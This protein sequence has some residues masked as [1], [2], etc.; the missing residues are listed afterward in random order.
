MEVAII[1][2]IF[3]T[4]D[5]L[6]NN[7]FINW[8]AIFRLSDSY[9]LYQNELIIY[10]IFQSQIKN[11]IKFMIIISLKNKTFSLME[12]KIVI[13]LCKLLIN[14]LSSYKI[15]KIILENN[16]WQ[17]ISEDLIYNDE[18]INLLSRIFQL[19]IIIFDLFAKKLQ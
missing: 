11:N 3:N 10:K 17:I 4:N 13:E 9:I 12:F 18:N 7:S 19:L 15:D 2:K 16:E 1:T 5:K 8:N 14:S 6:S